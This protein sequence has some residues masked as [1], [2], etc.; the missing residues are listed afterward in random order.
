MRRRPRRIG[1]VGCVS[2]KRA[3][4]A[5]AEKLYISTLFDGRRRFV[6]RTCDDWY[7]LSALHGLVHRAT[8]LEPYDV[9]LT[10]QGRDAKR[11]W[12]DGVLRQIESVVP[13]MKSVTFEI[14]AG[15]DYFDFGLSAGLERRG[16]QVVIPT[17][18]LRVGEQLRFYRSQPEPRR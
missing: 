11:R 10:G 1:L 6:E 12:A 8:V 15:A 13:K 9:A 5:P 7:V 16:A 2:Q 17:R 18:G 14:H 4:A 3:N